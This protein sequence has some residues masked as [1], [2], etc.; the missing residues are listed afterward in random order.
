M[1]VN[2]IG[3]SWHIGLWLYYMYFRKLLVFRKRGFV[4]GTVSRN[5]VILF[6]TDISFSW[7]SFLN[8]AVFVVKFY[9]FPPVKKLQLKRHIGHK[10]PCKL[11][12]WPW[13]N[14]PIPGDL[15]GIGTASGPISQFA[16]PFKADMA[17]ELQPFDYDNGQ[18]LP[19]KPA[20]ILKINDYNLEFLSRM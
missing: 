4:F 3:C 15:P 13:S 6:R 12:Y 11:W 8:V 7:H 1:I 10:W 2:H 17:F 9:I 16:W 18:V 20:I 19:Q 14:V 5:E